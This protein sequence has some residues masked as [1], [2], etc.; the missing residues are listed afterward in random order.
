MPASSEDT[1]SNIAQPNVIVPDLVAN[2]PST[3]SIQTDRVTNNNDFQ[4]PLTLAS[5]R[6][7][8]PSTQGSD[9]DDDETICQCPICFENWSNTGAHRIVSMKCGHLFGLSCIER[10]I[11]RSRKDV[12]P[13]CPQCNAIISKK[14]IRPVWAKRI[15][16]EDSVK[17]DKLQED[18]KTQQAKQLE[19]EV[20]LSKLHLAY[21]MSKH[22]LNKKDAEIQSLKS[23]ISNSVSNNSNVFR[24]LTSPTV[25]LIY[26]LQMKQ[27]LSFH[28]S[29]SR[30]AAIARVC[31]VMA[32][33]QGFDM[34]VASK[35]SSASEH[36]IQKISLVDNLNLET[37]T[38]HSRGIRDIQCSRSGLCLTTG[39][40][41]K[42][43]ITSLKDNC[44]VQSYNLG[45]AGWCCSWDQSDGNQL[46]CGLMDDSVMMFD[47]RN[48]R[49]Y[50]YHLKDHAKTNRKPIHS[51]IH[52]GGPTN[53][54]LCANLDR[55]YTWNLAGD[56]PYCSVIDMDYQDF[57]PYS[58]SYD[59]S[60]MTIL[61]SLRSQTATKHVHGSLANNH[62][63]TQNTYRNPIKQTALARTWH[64]SKHNTSQDNNTI[65]EFVVCAGD[66]EQKSLRMWNN[67][68]GERS[69]YVGSEILDIK[70]TIINNEV[71]LAALTG[72]EMYLYKD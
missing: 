47:V 3:S 53:S 54:V 6:K 33:N 48:T 56:E 2:V 31:R 11:C 37:I 60:S 49:D 20:A 22:E 38:I 30:F 27:K 43:K 55:L 13:K 10:W 28:T 32:F 44:I 17:L 29:V 58:V 57:H 4:S 19:Y 61:A 15:T 7:R 18:F 26:Q 21:E 9:S 36:A 24:R 14:D 8:E 63:E 51:L 34:I 67:E 52:I 41:G 59:K 69:I 50:V 46:Y 5:K 65:T 16:S 68:Y 40:D 72:N 62:F 12:K 66:E 35:S 1:E 64:F 23:M 42:A 39:L 71:Y 25:S 70:N 45:T